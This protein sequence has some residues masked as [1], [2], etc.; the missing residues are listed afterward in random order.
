MR[1]LTFPRSTKH[2][3][4][5]AERGPTGKNLQAS[6]FFKYPRGGVGAG[7]ETPSEYGFYLTGAKKHQGIASPA[8]VD[9]RDLCP[10]R[11]DRTLRPGSRPDRGRMRPPRPTVA[12]LL[13]FR[14]APSLAHAR[15]R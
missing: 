11:L 6:P 9:T 7:N 10:L 13:A 15:R 2:R 12:G 3:N 8:Q 5:R 4:L 14:R 1:R